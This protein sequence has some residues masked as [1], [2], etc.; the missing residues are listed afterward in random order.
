MLCEKPLAL[1]AGQ[2]DRMLAACA[3]AGAQRSI[4]H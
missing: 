3:E 1:G 4:C 2:V